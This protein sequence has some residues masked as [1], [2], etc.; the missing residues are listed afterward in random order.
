MTL[1]HFHIHPYTSIHFLPI[2]LT[3]WELNA[4]QLLWVYKG[5]VYVEVWIME[6]W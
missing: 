4:S 3:E 6:V 1:I 2:A 5:S